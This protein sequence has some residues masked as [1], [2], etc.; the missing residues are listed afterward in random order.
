MRPSVARLLFSADWRMEVSQRTQKDPRSPQS[1]NPFS[2]SKCLKWQFIVLSFSR[3]RQAIF[4]ILLTCQSRSR[5][6]SD[7][8]HTG[9]TSHGHAYLRHIGEFSQLQNNQQVAH[10]RPWAQ[11][12]FDEINL[13]KWENLLFLE[14]PNQFNRSAKI[15]V[16]LNFPNSQSN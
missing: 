15:Q 16:W 5:L 4:A 13:L 3:F 12:Q 10:N 14:T 7:N 1:I 8:L 6:T 11:I 2:Y 9:E